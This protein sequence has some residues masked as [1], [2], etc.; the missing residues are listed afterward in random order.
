MKTKLPKLPDLSQ[1]NFIKHFSLSNKLVAII[2]AVSTLALVSLL[3]LTFQKSLKVQKELGNLGKEKSDLT[4]SLEQSQKALAELENQDQ[5]KINKDL[6]KEILNIQ[7]TYKKAVDVYE[8]LLDL[9]TKTKDTEKLDD[10]LAKVFTLLSKR[11]YESAES[12]LASLSTEI[13]KQEDAI[14]STF[15]IPENVPASNT[16]PGSGYSRQS[17]TTDAGT[18]LVSMVAANLSSTKVIVDTASDSNC[19]DNCPVLSLAEYISRN[20]A[21]AGINGSYFCPASYPSCA[22]KTNSFD[23]L[24]MNYKKTYFNSDNNVYSSNPAVI[25]GDGYVRFVSSA[26][27]WGRDTSPY[28]VLSNYP[29]LLM[30]SEIKFSGGGDDKSVAKGGRSFV[31]NKGGTIYIGVVFSA[32]IA[33]SAKA[34]KSLGFENALNLDDGGST[35]LWSGGYKAGPGRNI[36]N[37]ILFVGK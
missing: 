22:G 21:F 16:P 6:E 19:S 23:L 18:F 1:N 35:A 11:D 32:T 31:A 28:G 9:K 15:K 5:Y 37:A 14:A 36:P 17:V 20:G 10:S 30:N 13:K 27:E 26:S 8:D 3:Y 2:F 7:N 33:E 12:E 25:F 34:M 4:T 29:L 24:V